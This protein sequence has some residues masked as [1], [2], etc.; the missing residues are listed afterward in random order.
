MRVAAQVLILAV[1]GYGALYSVAGAC[2]VLAAAAILAVKR[3][4]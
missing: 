1:G 4:R 2:A 3:V